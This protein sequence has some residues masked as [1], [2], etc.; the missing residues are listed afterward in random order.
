[1]Q[2]RQG[3]IFFEA[4]S[5]K[6]VLKKARQLTTNVLA[7]GEVTGHSHQ[8]FSPAL[9]ELDTMV[10]ENGDIFVYS[11]DKPITISHDEHGS[12]ELPAGQWFSITRQREYDP[13]AEMRE[14]KVAD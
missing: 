3:D 1:M 10:D 6:P 8:I 4:V 13:V 2:K 14:R 7:Y 11:K 12:I 5:K 9:S